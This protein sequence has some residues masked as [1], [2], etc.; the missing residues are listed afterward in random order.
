M[1]VSLLEV[2]EAGGYD[3]S[4]PEDAAWLI[5]QVNQ[6]EELVEEAE[7]MLEAIEE[8]ENE[9]L[10]QEYIKKYGSMEDE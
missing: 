7:D 9:R 1:S 3:L 8:A 4:T 6:F 2:I 5:S 10:E